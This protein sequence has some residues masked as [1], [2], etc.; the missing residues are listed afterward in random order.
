MKLTAEGFAR[1][2]K[3][4]VG[5]VS[6]GIP[7]GVVANGSKAYMGMFW[8]MVSSIPTRY[9]HIEPMAKD[10]AENVYG[11]STCIG[12]NPPSVDERVRPYMALKALG[13]IKD[14]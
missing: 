13:L 11:C 5:N 1:I 10:M 4:N 9:P 2:S 8:S 7:F 12:I 3:V 6:V 14:F